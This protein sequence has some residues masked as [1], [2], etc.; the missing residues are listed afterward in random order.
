MTDVVGEFNKSGDLV[1]IQV[2]FEVL[3]CPDCGSQSFIVLYD[4]FRFVCTVC[5]KVSSEREI[6]IK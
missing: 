2:K 6:L 1:S 3:R 4:P 5:E